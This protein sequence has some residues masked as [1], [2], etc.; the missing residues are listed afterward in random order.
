MDD[1]YTTKEALKTVKVDG[2][3]IPYVEMSM[4]DGND[5]ARAA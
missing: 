4:D 3:A 1:A 2:N 5:L